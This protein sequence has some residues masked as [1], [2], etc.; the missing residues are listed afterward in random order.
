MNL[1]LDTHIWL[2]SLLEPEKLS[3][4]ARDALSSDENTLWLSPISTWEVLILAEKGRLE[5]D[6]AGQDW[7]DQ[8]LRAAPMREAPLSHEIARVSRRLSLPH[9][10]PA[11][12]FIAATAKVLGLILMT[13]DQVLMRCDDLSVF[14]DPKQK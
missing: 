8:A 9:Q 4:P 10:G 12:R 14:P 7:V 11:D 3:S 6:T 2:W 13:A 5:L 1:L